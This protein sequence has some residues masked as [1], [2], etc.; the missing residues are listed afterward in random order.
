M[1]VCCTA[2]AVEPDIEVKDD[3]QRTIVLNQPAA[4]IVSLAPH[5]TELV[6]SAG[7]GDKLVG[8]S[9][10][11]DHP[12]AVSR[13]PKVSDH[14]TVNY[15]YL[16]MRRPDL[17]LVWGAGLKDT[18]LHKLVS[19]HHHVYVSDPADFEGI[20]DNLAEI[21]VLAGTAAHARKTADAFLR[22]VN[23]AASDYAQPQPV[24]T[25]YLIWH[26]P[27]MTIGGGHWISHAINLCGGVNVFADVIADT[28]KLNRESLQLTPI[29]IA[30]HSLQGYAAPDESATLGVKLGL[31]APVLYIEDDLIQRPSLRFIRGTVQL[32]RL[33]H[34]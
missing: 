2:A 18:T 30:L 25:L 24:K 5:L 8:V 27:L 17:I 3:L 32:C 26:D 31:N 9:R 28:V 14:T 6:Y 1:I 15:E 10:H 12:P 20:A 33:M 21:G 19:L 7:A 29:D 16:A 13:L 22:E 4:R 11:C 34:R 23:A